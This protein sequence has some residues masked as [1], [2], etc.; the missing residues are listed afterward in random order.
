MRI[1]NEIGSAEEL[2]RYLATNSWSGAKDRVI[3]ALEDGTYDDLV[4]EL[5]DLLENC[6]PEL[7]ECDLNDEVWFGDIFNRDLEED[8]DEE[9]EEEE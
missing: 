2:G 8:E 9:D 1:Y 5:Y 4:E 3:S 7:S 6:N